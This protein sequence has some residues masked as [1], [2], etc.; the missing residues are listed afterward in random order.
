MSLRSFLAPAIVLLAAG[1]SACGGEG[2]PRARKTDG[3][4]T[5]PT[6]VDQCKSA[7]DYTFQTIQSGD[8]LDGRNAEWYVNYDGIDLVTDSSAMPNA[9]PT[10]T[11]IPW[12]CPNAIPVD[13]QATDFALNF[14]VWDLKPPID[15]PPIGLLDGGT[16]PKGGWGALIGCNLADD[17]SGWEGISFWIRQE[18]EPGSVGSAFVSV[19][20]DHTDPKAIDPVTGAP[21]C[22]QDA[23][24]ETGSTAEQ[25]DSFGMGVAVYTDWTFYALP[26]AKMR[27]RGYGK[28]VSQKVFLKEGLKHL[29]GL[30][31]D[32]TPTQD[33]NIWLDGV[34]YYKKKSDAE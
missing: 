8:F 19:S 28:G 4:A 32:F 29:W 30:K 13:A 20:E 17:A 34:A 10:P 27:Q 11:E 7:L 21:P 25:C 1:A 14:S 26:F 18:A 6:A 16:P 23:D 3:L 2:G 22:E 15:Q 9:H 12:R 33:W 31:F 24:S 5:K